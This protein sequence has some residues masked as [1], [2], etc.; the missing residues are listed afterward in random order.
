AGATDCI[1]IHNII[2]RDAGNTVPF[3]NTLDG[4]TLIDA[5]NNRIGSTN[6]PTL[7]N[8]ITN[9][10]RNGIK[11]TSSGNGWANNITGNSIFGNH[12]LVPGLGIDL[13]YAPEAPDPTDNST[14]GQ[15]PNANYANF[16]QNAPVI[17]NAVPN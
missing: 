2:G 1:I 9:N 7:A 15:D 8:T 6:S 11:V 12:T 14:P 3:G 4:I 17:P 16:R 13:D 5:G 10:G